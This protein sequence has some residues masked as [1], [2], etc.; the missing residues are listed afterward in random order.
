V[1]GYS[2]RQVIALER[3]EQNDPLNNFASNEPF[4]R[5]VEVHNGIQLVSILTVDVE[6]SRTYWWH[7]RVGW[8]EA[9]GYFVPLRGWQDWMVEPAQ[10]VMLW[11][12][13]LPRDIERVYT[14]VQTD[15]RPSTIHKRIPLTPLERDYVDV[16]QSGTVEPSV[17]LRGPR[18]NVA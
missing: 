8:M 10:R 4:K 13:T 3:P 11:L 1:T 12:I 18:R 6:G 9:K 15:K 5:E 14:D 7:A 17:W 2:R 16:V